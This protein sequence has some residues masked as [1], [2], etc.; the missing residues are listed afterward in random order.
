MNNTS[1]KELVISMHGINYYVFCSNDNTK[2]RQYGIYAESCEDS[3][4][5]QAAGNL[6][7]T[8]EEAKAY[9]KWFAEN[10]VYPITLC[11]VLANIY[12]MPE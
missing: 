4:D 10:E 6:F 7:F 1:E 11:D 8:P 12:H 5:F 9:S 3:T 2:E